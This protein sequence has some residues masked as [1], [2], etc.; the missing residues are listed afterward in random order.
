MLGRIAAA[1]AL[2]VVAL[3]A[4]VGSVA[5]A[6]SAAAAAG[7]AKGSVVGPDQ[8]FR[9]Q[10][11]ARTGF[12]APVTIQMACYGPLRLGQTGHP[13]PGQNVR[14]LLGGGNVAQAGFTGPHAVSIGVFFGPPPPSAS[15]LTVLTVTRY[16]VPRAI[17]TSLVLPCSGTGQVT[18]V[19]LPMSPPVSTDVVVPVRFV[20]QP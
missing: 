2:A 10:V 3:V 12:P 18:F 16:G 17:A 14:V 8:V 13:L 4:P 20:G 19:P 15:A 6:A 11:N 1:A 9:A 5:S 7:S